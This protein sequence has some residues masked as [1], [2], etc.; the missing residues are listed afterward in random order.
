MALLNFSRCGLSL[1]QYSVVIGAIGVAVLTQGI[2]KSFP[3]M[4]SSYVAGSSS[5][6]YVTAPSEDVAKKLAHSLVHQKMAACV[7]IIPKVTSVYEWEGKI[8]EDSEVLMMIKTRSSCISDIVQ[9]IKK[10]H[11]YDCPEIISLPIEAGSD[12]YLKWVEESVTAPK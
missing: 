12:Q 11:P 2:S 8:N 3:K 10:E 5:V 6:A 7:N 9:L 1:G 4:A